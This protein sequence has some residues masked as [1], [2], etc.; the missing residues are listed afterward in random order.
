MLQPAASNASIRANV[1]ANVPTVIV[2]HAGT[3]AADLIGIGGRLAEGVLLS[4]KR[5]RSASRAVHCALASLADRRMHTA[6]SVAIKEDVR[7]R[8]HKSAN[9]V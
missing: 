5:F 2:F 8:N 1:F 6:H 9:N 7:S 3:A 4:V